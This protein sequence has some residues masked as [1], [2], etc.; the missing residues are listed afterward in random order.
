MFV[1]AALMG[2]MTFTACTSGDIDMFKTVKANEG[3]PAVVAALKSI[4]NVA[5]VKPFINVG[6]PKNE[7]L[8]LGQCYY[9]KYKQPIDHDNPALGTYEQQVVLTYVSP[10]APTIL[11]TQGY[12]LAGEHGKNH[13]RL[14]SIIA[15]MF[16][17][18]LATGQ[19]ADGSLKFSTNCVQVE[20]RYHGF[21][22]PEGDENSFKYLSA[23]QKNGMTTYDYAYY[24]P[25]DVDVYVPFVAP[26][27][28]QNE[29]MRIGDYMINSAVKD[30][31]PQI[32]AAF[33]KLVSDQ[34]VLDAT[35][36]YALKSLYR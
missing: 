3:D 30:Y 32:K 4:P 25:G 16:M 18:M 7:E 24:Y 31:L 11:H 22:L 13:N 14:D 10:D 21:S 9:I 1:I 26:L 28:F 15:P 23:K 29:D 36:P 8:A 34:K 6:R 33:Q 27:L 19:N 35:A 5:E 17:Y 20:Y 2:S 12:A